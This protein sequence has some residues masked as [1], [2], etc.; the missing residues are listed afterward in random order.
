MEKRLGKGLA[1]IIE[2]T[3]QASPNFVLLRTNQIRPCRYQP[4]QTID[5]GALEE[6]KS[7]I[8]RHGIIEPIIVRPIAHGSY[9][10]VAGER[11]WR[12]AQAIGMEEVPAIIRAL[13]DQETI[14]YSLIEN[15]QR[16][17][18][19]AI[20]EARAFTRL[21][22]EFGYT[23][24]QVAETVGKDRAT[25]SNT[26]RLLKLPDE[27]QAALVD[28]R[29]TAGHAKALLSIEA[30]PKQLGL[31]REIIKKQLSVRAVEELA[32]PWQPKTRRKRQGADPQL[33]S[34]ENDIRQALGTKVSLT[35]RKRGGRIVIEYFSQDDLTRIL[36]ALGVSG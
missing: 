35:S 32:G 21:L 4:R 31:F 15:L 23:H 8:K 13:S 26:L 10:L 7:S 14:E 30:Q 27:I 2:A 3:A 11:R 34:I 17:D 25:I 18:L 33:Q 22:G 20:E 9:E 36:Q 16:E 5:E 29:I 24:D 1:Q 28:G 6:L 19:N 12:A